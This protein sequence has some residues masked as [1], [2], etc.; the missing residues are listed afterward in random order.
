MRLMLLLRGTRAVVGAVVSAAASAVVGAI[1][2][3]WVAC[4]IGHG[5]SSRN[6]SE[7]VVVS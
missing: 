6:V 2:V 1:A 5:K 7:L 3:R 4:S